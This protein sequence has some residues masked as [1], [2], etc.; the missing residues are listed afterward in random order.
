MGLI[1]FLIGVAII[2]WTFQQAY[3]MFSVPPETALN[4]KKGNTLDV[5]VAAQSGATIVYRIALLFL[6]TLI[7]SII[8]NRG[9]K[10]YSESQKGVPHAE[11][12]TAADQ[13][14][15]K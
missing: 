11:R 4:I 13:N 3:T 14:P 9:I 12:G 7:G 5:N 10:L 6:M 15:G 1:V 8:S 2:L